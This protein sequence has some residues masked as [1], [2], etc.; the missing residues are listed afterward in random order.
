MFQTIV[1]IPGK[2]NLPN[3]SN[4]KATS[5]PNA[6]PNQLRGIETKERLLDAA[7][8]LFAE[9]GFDG[10]SM[11]ALTEAAGVNVSAANYHFGSKEALLRATLLRRIEP[12]NRRRLDC[13]DALERDAAGRPLAIESILAVFLRPVFDERAAS[14]DATSRFRQVAAR[15]YSDPPEVVDAMKRELFG[16]IM[17]RFVDALSTSLPDTPRREIELGF[18]LSVGVVVHVISGHLE[19]MLAS[20]DPALRAGGAALSDESLFEQMIAYMAAGLRSKR[21]RPGIR[22]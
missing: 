21:P 17:V 3:A 15:L 22:P 6:A 20:K 8:K 19:S 2:P 14:V 18:Q 10:A 13:L 9:R 12:L 4:Q 16:P 5:S 1:L 11:R 7:E